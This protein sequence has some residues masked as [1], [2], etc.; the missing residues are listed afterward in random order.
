MQYRG[1]Y[2]L[3]ALINI[4][5]YTYLL[6]YLLQLERIGCKC[7]D[8]WRRSYIIFVCVF[9]IGYAF[10]ELSLLLINTPSTFHVLEATKR[11]ALPLHIVLMIGFVVS[12]FQYVGRLE[13]EKCACSEDTAKPIL[14]LVAMVNTTVLTIVAL[15]MLITAISY[16]AKSHK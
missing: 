2:A 9:Y 7:A 8:D 5:L 11:W 13:R 14:F 10:V 4:F 3:A 16:A 6:D 1:V 15:L 12:A